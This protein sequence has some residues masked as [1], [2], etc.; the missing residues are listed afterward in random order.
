VRRNVQIQ[1]QIVEI[2]FK[3]SETCVKPEA[4]GYA[5]DKI[6]N[7]KMLRKQYQEQCQ[8]ISFQID[9]KYRDKIEI[10]NKLTKCLLF[11]S[12]QN[13]STW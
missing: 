9:G 13:I 4:I 12:V 10:N 7:Y 11:F 1:K 2:I 5:I 3:C 6:N 8:N